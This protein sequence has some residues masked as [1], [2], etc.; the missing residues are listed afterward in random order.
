MAGEMFDFLIFLIGACLVAA[1]ILW[2][3]KWLFPQ[4]YPP[5]RYIVGALVLIAILVKLK[6]F[7]VAALS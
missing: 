5:A 7:I 6:P 2:A 1:L 4:I 3:V